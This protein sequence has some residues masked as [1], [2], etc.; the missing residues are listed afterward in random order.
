MFN[1]LINGLFY[2]SDYSSILNGN[3]ISYKISE[4]S[5]YYYYIETMLNISMSDWEVDVLLQ[6][7]SKFS[8]LK[9]VK[10]PIKEDSNISTIYQSTQLNTNDSTNT[11]RGSKNIGNKMSNKE[12]S[13]N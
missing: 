9:N 7:I 11:R 13:K 1:D 2:E 4:D 10:V 5:G 12:I 8:L 3:F 6:Y